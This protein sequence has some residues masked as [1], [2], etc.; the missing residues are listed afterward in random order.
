MQ[1]LIFRECD[2]LFAIDVS[3]VR[4]IMKWDTLE[5][6]DIPGGN[7]LVKG[8]IFLRESPI[9]ILDAF[10]LLNLKPCEFSSDASV[11]VLEDVETNQYGLTCNDVVEIID[12][13]DSKIQ[14]DLVSDS[15]S[16][17]SGVFL[18]KQGIAILL[19]GNKIFNDM[20]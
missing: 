7:A 13:D 3:H 15:D 20:E 12:I 1:V 17:C 16:Y 14:T 8:M 19:D 10:S 5:L 2:E 4:E 6:N 11:L 18:Y 9:I